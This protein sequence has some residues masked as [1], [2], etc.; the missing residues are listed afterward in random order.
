MRSYV[1]AI[2]RCR[3]FW[4]ALVGMDLRTRYRG[5]ILGM[6]W[7]LL[8]PIAMTVVLCTVFHTLFHEDIRNYAPY[9]LCGLAYWNFVLAVTV[10]SCMC[11]FHGEAY[12]RQCP[13]PLA[14]YPLR[15]TLGGST[16]FVIALV[17]VIAASWLLKGVQNPVALLSLI[18]TLAM[19]FILGWSLS[20]LMGFA[21]V[22]FQD[23]Q[24]LAEVVCQVLFYAT[25]IIYRSDRL[26]QGSW[27]WLLNL[28]PFAPF[29]EMLRLPI[30]EGRFP[31]GG[32]LG[33]AAGITATA[34]G[35]AALTLWRLQGRLV[36]RL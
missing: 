29:L 10:H 31:A 2:W 20:L 16:H 18:P 22:F 3:H 25:P 14:I 28:N 17:V 26:P 7:S 34:F 24:H 1:A 5:S 36:F 11:F 6:G 13:A 33:L 35:A 12:I 9:V 30:L 8:Q 15:A 21:N 27:S 23:T 32:T 19:L 4:K